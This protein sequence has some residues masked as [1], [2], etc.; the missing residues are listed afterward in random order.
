MEESTRWEHRLQGHLMRTQT[1]LKSQIQMH[2]L[3]RIAGR[4][5]YLVQDRNYWELMSL[6]LSCGAYRTILLSMTMVN[7]VRNC[8]RRTYILLIRKLPD[9]LRGIRRKHSYTASCMV[10]EIRRSVRSWVK[11]EKKGIH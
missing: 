1:S 3:G 9:Y 5:L 6:V 10:Q 2:P 4:Y 11:G 8:W 7:M